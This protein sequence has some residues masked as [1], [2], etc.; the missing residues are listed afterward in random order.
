MYSEIIKRDGRLV[1]FDAE[2]ITSAI[3]KAGLATGEFDGKT[4]RKLTIRALSLA[5][6]LFGGSTPSV[7]EI[8]DIVEE[9]LLST[10]YRRTAK[11]YIIYRDQHARL[12]E[13]T[14][15]MEVELVDS[16]L[17]KKDWK[18]NENSNMDYSL[19]G[20]NNYISSEVSKIYWLNE[21]YSPE[22]RKAHSDGDFHI[23]DLSL[24]SVYCVGWDL[25]DLLMNGFKGV[26]GK[27]ESRPA[28]HLRS[29]LGQVVNFFYT[30]QGEAAGAQAFSNFDTLLAPFIRYDG[31]TFDEV[32]QALQE[33]IFNINVPTRVGFQTPFTN[34]TLDVTVPR[35]YAGQN[36]IIGGEP[37]RETYSE[38]QEEMNLFNSAFLQVMAE[39]DAKGRVFTFPIPTYNITRDFNWDDPNLKD[40]W[41]MTAKYGVPYFSNFI[42]SE[43][44][45]EDARSMC[46]RLRIDNRQLQVRGGGLFGSNP[47]TGSIGVITMNM[48]RIGYLS[49]SEHHFLDRLDRLMALARESLETK[50]KVLENFTDRNLYPYTKYY[51]RGVKERFG[52][53][54]KNHFST[55]GLVGMN[56]ACLNL[57]GRSIGTREG[58]EF[59]KRVLD[60]MRDRLVEFQNETGN[61]Y[62]LESTPAE[63]TS[64]RLAQ[65]DRKKYPDILVAASEQDGAEKGEPFYTN[66]TQLPVNYTDDLF[67]ALDL[68]DEIQTKYTGG[69]VF[70]IFAGERIEDPDIIKKLIQRICSQYH[71]PYLTFTPTF[72]VCPSHGYLRGEQAACPECQEPCEIYSRVVGYL[73][74]VKQ[75][76]KG[77]QQEFSLRREYAV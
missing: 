34:V 58:Q 56:E 10:S 47:L 60:F 43:M 21:V 9:V 33:F 63:G 68:Q 14:N 64:Y 61:N 2:K 38:F 7:E 8:Q 22:V 71:I 6:K 66:S 30:L 39:G 69:T 75:W 51:L 46:C 25:L 45:P 35:Y 3:A 32:K 48:P 11:A 15:R 1:K 55:I 53:Y 42:N 50:R 26:S 62:N 16:Y 13:I 18:I 57:F 77:K 44:N 5:E 20:L 29:A 28:R 24:L 27:V 59:A 23:H 19:Q 73:R 41:E 31:L 70:H 65:M 52:E 76:N 54:W 36:V 37:R 4:A 67:E 72:S 12:R 49:N 74:P 17:K 40:L